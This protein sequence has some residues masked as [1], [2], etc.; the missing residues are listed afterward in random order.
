MKSAKAGLLA[1]ALLLCSCA[2][3]ASMQKQAT[4]HYQMGL[5][6]LGQNNFTSALI[7]L[8]EAE[9]LT[10][11]DPLLLNSL[12]WA[13]FRKNRYELAEQKFLRALALKPQFTEARRNLGLNYM[14]MKL[15]DDAIRQFR[16]VSDDIFYPDQELAA[17]NLG[18]SYYGKGDYQN[19][20]KTFRYIISTNPRNATAHL[21]LGR[22]YFADERLNAAI[23]EYKKAIALDAGY[24]KAYYF[25]GLAHL[26]KSDSAS[27]A[28]AFREAVRL[29]PDSE[30][31][32]LSK[33]NL[34]V[35]K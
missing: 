35:L 8:T 5:S 6:Y 22:T 33:E 30:V 23:E 10:P 11:D 1:L 15:W 27:A 25:L 17:V 2:M 26:K 13:Y 31:G 28:S 9:K 21:D 3:N 34:E 24:A 16:I 20:M 12:G 18:R 19:A 7:E 29:A 32:L 4:Y 14:E